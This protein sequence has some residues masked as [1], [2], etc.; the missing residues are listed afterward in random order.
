MY[1]V[2]LADD[3]QLI[4]EGLAET[5]P[6][7]SLRMRLVGT[8]EDGR[9]ALRGIREHKPDIVLTDIRMPYLDGLELIGKIREVH[10][11]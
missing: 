5:I 3:E 2:Y 9:H 11:S 8:A 6:W 10:P 7:E 4:R 1:T